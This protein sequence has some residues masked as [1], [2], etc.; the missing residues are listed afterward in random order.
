MLLACRKSPEGDVG[1]FM[2]VLPQPNS[3]R[4]NARAMVINWQG[5]A[6]NQVFP[7]MVLICLFKVLVKDLTADS[8]LRTYPRARPEMLIAELV[9]KNVGL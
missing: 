8:G 3:H 5:Y 2:G 6:A 9:F 1:C 4:P 7:Y